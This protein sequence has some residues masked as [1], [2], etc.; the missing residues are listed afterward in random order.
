MVARKR[1]QEEMVGFVMIMIVVAIIMLI[2]LAIW[3]RQGAQDTDV[4][5]TEISQFLDAM[6]EYTTD[7]ARFGTSYLSVDELVNLCR[8]GRACPAGPRAQ[9]DACSIIEETSQELIESSWNFGPESLEKSYYFHIAQ[10]T[11]G[12][13]TDY[14]AVGELCTGAV[15]GDNKPRS[16]DVV[17]ELDICL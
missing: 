6:L 16:N 3:V 13:T 1:G 4:T 2:F 9:E 14:V 17:I 7:C 11:G 12:I 5:S 10:Q 15:R 8:D